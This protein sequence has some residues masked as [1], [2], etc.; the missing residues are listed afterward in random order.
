MSSSFAFSHPRG[1]RLPATRRRLR[2]S[3]PEVVSE[4]EADSL[5]TLSTA[6]DRKSLERLDGSGICIIAANALPLAQAVI[7]STRS[8]RANTRGGHVRTLY[9]A[10]PGGLRSQG[11]RMVITTFASL[12]STDTSVFELF[13]VFASQCCL[14]SRRIGPS[15]STTWRLEIHGRLGSRNENDP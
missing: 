14:V 15:Y 1:L 11:P 6:G 10:S 8:V 9:A 12:S 3:V 7:V 13:F 2:R 5:P 4:F